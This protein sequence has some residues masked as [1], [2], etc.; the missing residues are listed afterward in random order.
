MA[1]GINF[2][3]F[4]REKRDQAR[5]EAK[6]FFQDSAEKRELLK[7]RWRI[8]TPFGNDGLMTPGKRSEL[9]EN[10]YWLLPF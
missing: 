3:I 8:P 4:T 7:Y 9:H 6:L 2:G 10:G 1:P 5:R